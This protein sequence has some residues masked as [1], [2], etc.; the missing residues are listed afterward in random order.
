MTGYAIVTGA[1]RN[2]GAAI[3]ARLQQDGYRVI[4]L[5]RIAPEHSDY[6]EY[7]RVDLTDSESTRNA[8]SPLIHRMPVTCLINNAGIVNPATLEDTTPADFDQVM[9]AN[10]KPAVLLAQMVIP[11]MK[12]AGVG[13]IVNISSRAA[14]GKEMRTAYAAS[15][16]ALLGMTRTWALELARYGI[17]VNAVGP[18]PIQTRLF[19][20]ANPPGSPQ[21]EAIL[22]SIPVGYL[23]K[24]ADVAEAVA[25]FA[26]PGAHFITG[27]TLFVCGGMTIGAA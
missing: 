9:A 16:A 25:F 20:D 14:L 23:G 3:C 1:A 6:A 2:I 5:D 24:P 22:R 21:T 27:Q 26:S 19:E 10:A 12:S 13:R 8:L 7:V 17:T 11:G 15:K 18:G 4:A